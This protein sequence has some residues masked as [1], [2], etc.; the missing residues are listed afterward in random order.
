MTT[1]ATQAVY[2]IVLTVAVAA[3]ASCQTQSGGAARE[4]RERSI[5]ATSSVPVTGEPT[6]LPRDTPI[7]KPLK[8]VE[9][10]GQ[11]APGYLHGGRGTCV[12]N[13]PCRGFG[14]EDEKGQVLCSCYG[15]IGGCGLGHRCDD[16]KL[17]CVDDEEPPFNKTR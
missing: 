9:T 5:E 15:D 16:R 11:C 13:Q 7:L 2:V 3:I 17:A 10:G 14:V 4:A 12:N 6:V 1:S 8:R